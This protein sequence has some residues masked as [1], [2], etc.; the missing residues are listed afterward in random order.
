MYKLKKKNV[1]LFLPTILV[2]KFDLTSLQKRAKYSLE[3]KNENYMCHMP[4]LRN[5]ITYDH[6]FWSLV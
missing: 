3:Q 5:S 2:E 6:D 1:S 4:Y